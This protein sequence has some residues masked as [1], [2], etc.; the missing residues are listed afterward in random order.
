[1]T[2][3]AAL[4]VANGLDVGRGAVLLR[5]VEL[6]VHAGQSWFVVGSNGSGKTTLLHTLL[7]LL[8]PLAGTI[9]LGPQLRDRRAVGFVPQEPAEVS[10][11]P[12]TVAEYVALGC[13][14]PR[15]AATRAA[16]TRGL[17]AMG[18]IALAPRDVR[19]LSLGHRRRVAIARALARA[20]VLLVLDEPTANL[21]TAAGDRL[22][23]DLR[24]LCADGMTVLHVSHD[25]DDAERFASHI[26]CVAGGRV[27]TGPVQ[28]FA[29]RLRGLLQTDHAATRAR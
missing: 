27:V 9:S 6:Q 8:P 21:D 26:A 19:Q 10:A 5:A 18:I 11:L 14:T 20:P 3:P 4:L 17:E 25:L 13:H 2:E 24:Q 15:G 7:G 12:C 1:M 28:Q 23:A 29:G 16:V 22:L